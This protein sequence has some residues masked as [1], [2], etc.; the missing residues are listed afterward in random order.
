MLSYGT[1]VNVI[2]NVLKRNTVLFAANFYEND[3]CSTVLCAEFYTEFYPPLQLNI[4]SR[5]RN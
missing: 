3:K 5:H 1:R 2:V 4:Q